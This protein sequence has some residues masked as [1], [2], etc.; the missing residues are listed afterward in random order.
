MKMRNV[1]LILF[2]L[3]LVSLILFPILCMDEGR[4]YLNYPWQLVPFGADSLSQD[5]KSE[6]RI[7]NSHA[8]MTHLA[9]SSKKT[10]MILVDGWGVPYDEK[11]LE[12]DFSLF[13]QEH[14]TFTIHQRLLGH[15]LHAENVEYR[16]GF[17]GGV[18][19]MQGDSLVCSQRADSAYWGF[20][21]GFC[22]AN[23]NDSKMIAIIDS[24]LSDSARMK[25]GWTVLSTR[26][27]DRKKLHEVLRGLS[28]VASRHPDVQFVIQGTHRPILGTPETR[29]KHLAPWVP[30][31]FINCELKEIP[32]NK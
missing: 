16:T 26:E 14:A 31:V 9:D 4:S 12:Q 5:Y 22:C 32:K 11:K 15:T 27:G 19:L 21:Q 29:R 23:C 3:F 1:N 28:D 18:F 24:L 30:A 20:K 17:A 13:R 8:L 6:Y 2:S 25:L 10:T 7:L